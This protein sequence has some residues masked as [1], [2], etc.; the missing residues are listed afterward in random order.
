MKQIDELEGKYNG[1]C[2]PVQKLSVCV[3]RAS[4]MS[5]A[6]SG[7]A[8]E[9]N[10][11]EAADIY[12]RESNSMRAI[13]EVVIENCNLGIIRYRDIYE[14]EFVKLFQDKKLEHRTINEFS[15]VL[16]VSKYN[17][18]ANKEDVLEEDLASFI[19]IAHADPY[20]P[21]MPLIDIKNA[22]RS[23][24]VNKRINVF[25][26]AS[27]YDLLQ[28]VENSFMWMSPVEQEYLDKYDIV[29]KKVGF[30]DSV[31]KDVL[32]YRKGYRLTAYEELFLKNIEK[33][34]ESISSK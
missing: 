33:V 22:L 1:E 29:Q 2:I 25:E 7:F 19:E 27:Q 8:R 3:P 13:N 23:N 16:A 34:K 6:I 10:I 24:M 20:V 11:D 5:E 17:V 12:Y 30:N 21:N 9:I 26:R 4:Y 18:L 14:K 31:Y 32:I 28:N 15:Y